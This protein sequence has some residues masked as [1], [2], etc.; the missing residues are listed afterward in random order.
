MSIKFKVAPEVTFKVEG[1]IREGGKTSRFDFELTA[2]RI[3]QDEFTALFTEGSSA[4]I[5]DFLAEKTR[6]WRGVNDED[7][8]A[9]PYSGDNLRALLNEYAGSG[10]LALT[11][12]IE[13]V[14]V[15]GRRK[16]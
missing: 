5:A 12:Y 10:Q 13:A 3:S 15:K 16:N 9:V 11:A 1:E 7:G 4:L 8:T 2:D 6:G 14:G